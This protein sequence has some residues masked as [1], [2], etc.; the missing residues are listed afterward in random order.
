MRFAY[1]S[2]GVMLSGAH[3]SVMALRRDVMLAIK[4]DL[5]WPGWPVFVRDLRY[6]QHVLSGVHCHTGQR[7]RHYSLSANEAVI[8]IEERCR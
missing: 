6:A 3:Y 8:F 5:P 1:G 2:R 4:Q 7:Q